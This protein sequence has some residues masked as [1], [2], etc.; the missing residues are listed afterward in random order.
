MTLGDRCDQIVALID[1]V[2]DLTLVSGQ[3]DGARHDDTRM[4]AVVEAEP[5]PE[6]K[7]VVS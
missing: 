2:L 4:T 7:W 6:P 3:R 5:S 1:E